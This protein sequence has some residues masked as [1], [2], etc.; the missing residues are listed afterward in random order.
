MSLI[1][2]YATAL[3][4]G[5]VHALEADHM[6]AVTSFAVR[7]PRWREAVGFGLRWAFGHGAV[8]VV[9]GA[10][11][12]LIGIRI[13]QG[14]THV[15]ERLV[16]LVLIGL[17]AWTVRGARRIHAHKH[18]H[19]DGTSHVHLHSHAFV[20]DHDHRHGATAVGMLH[21]LAGTAPGVALVPIASFDSAVQGVIYLLLFAV[22]TAGGM[23]LYALL[24]GLVVGRAAFRS[25]RLARK[26]AAVTGCITIAVGAFWM[27]R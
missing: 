16:G 17:G 6:A 8:V 25:E 3:L 22:G 14:A 21:G 7:R 11:M 15:L 26:T 18:S 10:V 1:L 27:V 23:A 20:R 24:A 19:A 13:P 5:S 12:L 9:A 4:V 2:L